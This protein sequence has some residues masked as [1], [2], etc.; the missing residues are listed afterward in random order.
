M[1]SLSEEMAHLKL[2]A[3]DQ[4]ALQ[5]RLQ[6]VSIPLYAHM[7]MLEHPCLASLK[8]IMVTARA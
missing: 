8:K 7:N 2:K 5:K 6:E 4:E 3:A 1:A